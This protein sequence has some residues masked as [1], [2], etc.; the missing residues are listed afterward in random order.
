[1]SAILQP[2]VPPIR[3]TSPANTAIAFNIE[4]AGWLLIPPAGQVLVNILRADIVRALDARS[5]LTLT[6]PDPA[7]DFKARP[8]ASFI[9]GANSC[10][11]HC[12]VSDFRE[13][14][15]TVEDELKRIG[16]L[17]HAEIGWLCP[18]EMIWRRHWPKGD[19]SPFTPKI[20][21]DE[22]K[23]VVNTKLLH[24]LAWL[25]RFHPPPPTP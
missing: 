23:R 7:G 4:I 3:Q 13:A 14:L 1:M 18:A 16:L 22:E 5:L 10:Y 8:A 20:L 19:N 15:V 11:G 6:Q 21:E 25:N 9:D 12:L 17:E 24:S 2:T